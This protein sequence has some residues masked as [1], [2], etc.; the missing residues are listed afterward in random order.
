VAPVDSD[1]RHSMAPYGWASVDMGKMAD[2]RSHDLMSWRMPLPRSPQAD[3]AYPAD[4]LITRL[5]AVGFYSLSRERGVY[6]APT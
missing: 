2:I 3:S 5:E 6:L 4:C 1:I